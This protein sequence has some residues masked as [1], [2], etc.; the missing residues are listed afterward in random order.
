MPGTDA[1]WMQGHQISPGL[2]SQGNGVETCLGFG[3]RG[4]SADSV[5][6]SQTTLG[7]HDMTFSN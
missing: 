1:P 6:L 2:G 3:G 5:D 4:G 7:L